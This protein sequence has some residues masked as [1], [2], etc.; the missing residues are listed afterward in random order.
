[1]QISV[2]NLLFLIEFSY[3]LEHTSILNKTKSLF[4]YETKEQPN[5]S[6]L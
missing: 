3:K 6:N 4:D 2:F 1:M 5:L